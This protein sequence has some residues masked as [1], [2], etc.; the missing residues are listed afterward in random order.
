MDEWEQSLL[1]YNQQWY[2]QKNTLNRCFSQLFSV[3]S[4]GLLIIFQ[5]RLQH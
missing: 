4:K 1:K 3:F 5:E 2:V